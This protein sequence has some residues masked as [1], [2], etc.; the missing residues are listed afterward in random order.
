MKSA[1][2]EI[3]DFVSELYENGPIFGT[4]LAFGL[5]IMIPG[6]VFAFGGLVYLIARHFVVG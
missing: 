5:M 3:T 2:N 1:R 6:T 4:F